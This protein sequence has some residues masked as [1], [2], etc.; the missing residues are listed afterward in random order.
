MN[1]RPTRLDR[2]LVPLN[3]GGQVRY[4]NEGTVTISCTVTIMNND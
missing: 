2:A 3:A 4:L 1:K